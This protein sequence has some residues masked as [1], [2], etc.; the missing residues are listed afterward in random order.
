MAGYKREDFFYDCLM[1]GAEDVDKQTPPDGDPDGDGGIPAPVV[2]ID[3]G[4][5]LL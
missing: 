5:F 4:I 3:N 2:D 1:K